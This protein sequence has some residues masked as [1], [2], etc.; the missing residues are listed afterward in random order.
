MLRKKVLLQMI[1]DREARIALL[2]KRLDS[3]EQIVDGYRV[4]EQ[5]II[6]AIAQAQET[7]NRRIAETEEE[8]SARKKIAE[9]TAASVTREAEQEANSL[10]AEAETAA[11]ELLKN[12]ETESERRLRQTEA[13]VAEFDA[14]LESY[15]AE[16][17]R[18][19][20]EAEDYAARYAS[21]IKTRR[22]E[23]SET[24][25]SEAQGLH[26]LPTQPEIPLPDPSDDPAQLMQNIYKIQN[27]SIPEDALEAHAAQ[28]E[29]QKQ[30]AE[31]PEPE[32]EP[33]PQPEAEPQP[34]LEP[35]PE[36]EDGETVEPEE[37]PGEEPGEEPWEPG[38]HPM[39]ENAEAAQEE[40]AAVITVEALLS[41]DGSEGNETSDRGAYD[42]DALLDEII[43]AGDI[44]ENE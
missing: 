32:F 9:E 27:R 5:S 25:Q 1:S 3:M 40:E 13:T 26:T 6:E 2:E 17:E 31:A 41:G 8:I 30:A 34:E 15:N 44:K 24:L 14:M 37:E 21:Y 16:L 19:A 36:P 29:E 28:A 20:R 43:R 22:V 4:R 12:A 33:E 11:K 35:G 7:V 42:F 23:R 18:A 39:R 38:M 10:Y